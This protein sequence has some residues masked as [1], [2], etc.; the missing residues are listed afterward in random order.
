MRLG[1]HA[2][3]LS[4]MLSYRTPVLLPPTNPVPSYCAFSA[5]NV[6]L[7]GAALALRNRSTNEHDRLI[8]HA[9]ACL[10]TLQACASGEPVAARYLDTITP[11]YEG[12]RRLR[13]SPHVDFV[14][15]K[16]EHKISIHDLL[17]KESE[18]VT[19]KWCGVDRELPGLMGM[20]TG[21]LKDPFGRVQE[22][23]TQ[24]YPTPPSPTDALFWFR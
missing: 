17:S 14:R 4:C 15:R 5:C 7:F 19:E 18:T 11:I 9:H 16:S 24:P 21:L 1:L 22:S 6:L 13:E 23:S 20:V 8:S 2:V 12:L 10:S 3:G